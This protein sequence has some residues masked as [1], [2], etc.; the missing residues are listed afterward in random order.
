LSTRP[1]LMYN[2]NLRESIIS[3][4]APLPEGDH[5]HLMHDNPEYVGFIRRFQRTIYSIPDNHI[6]IRHA[7]ENP[8]PLIAGNID[9]LA[10]RQEAW[11]HA[12]PMGDATLDVNRAAYRHA[13]HW[14]FPDPS[15]AA[16]LLVVAALSLMPEV[17]CIC[18]A[19]YGVYMTTSQWPWP[20]GPVTSHTTV[21]E[22]ALPPPTGSGPPPL[23]NLVSTTAYICSPGAPCMS[24]VGE[25]PDFDRAITDGFMGQVTGSFAF[26]STL[27]VTAAL[28]PTSQMVGNY[29]TLY[30]ISSWQPGGVVFSPVHS[31]LSTT[32]ATLTSS[33]WCFQIDL[34]VD[35]TTIPCSQ[36]PDGGDI[37]ACLDPM[38]S[39][40]VKPWM[41]AYPTM[42]ALST[43]SSCWL[44]DPD[45]QSDGSGGTPLPYL[46]ACSWASYRSWTPRA[47]VCSSHVVGWALSAPP[48]CIG[49]TT[50]YTGPTSG[51]APIYLPKMAGMV[52]QST[53]ATQTPAPVTILASPT[54]ATALGLQTSSDPGRTSIV[55]TNYNGLTSF[56]LINPITLDCGPSTQGVPWGLMS[57]ADGDT[58]ATGSECTASSTGGGSGG[59]YDI[60]G[61]ILVL[62]PLLLSLVTGGSGSGFS[63]QVRRRG[64]FDKFLV[65]LCLGPFCAAHQIGGGGDGSDGVSVSDF[66]KEAALTASEMATQTS[67]DAQMDTYTQSL[68]YV[69][70]NTSQNLYAGVQGVMRETSHLGVDI[71]ADKMMVESLNRTLRR[72][73]ASTMSLRLGLRDLSFHT[74]AVQ[75]LVSYRL[76][77]DRQS[78]IGST[79]LALSQGQGCAEAVPPPPEAGVPPVGYEVVGPLSCR[80]EYLGRSAA[81]IRY[82]LP[83]QPVNGTMVNVTIYEPVITTREGGPLYIATWA[84]PSNSS[85]LQVSSVMGMPSA[86]RGA[87]DGR[88]IPPLVQDCTRILLATPQ[89]DPI[90]LVATWQE[91]TTGASVSTDGCPSPAS[92]MKDAAGLPSWDRDVEVESGAAAVSSILTNDGM[93]ALLSLTS[94]THTQQY[95]IQAEFDRLVQ[96]TSSRTSALVTE[97]EFASQLADLA[98]AGTAQ[99]NA[100]SSAL[101]MAIVTS[102]LLPPPDGPGSIPDLTQRLEAARSSLGSR[103]TESTSAQTASLLEALSAVSSSSQASAVFQSSTSL[104]LSGI[105]LQRDLDLSDTLNTQA[106]IAS[107]MSTSQS[108]LMDRLSELSSLHA[109]MSDQVLNMTAEISAM[110]QFANSVQGLPSNGGEEG[111]S[112][113]DLSCW[114]R[115]IM[116]FLIT[117]AVMAAVLYVFVTVALPLGFAALKSASKSA[118]FRSN[119]HVDTEAIPTEDHGRSAHPPVRSAWDHAPAQ[120]SSTDG[121]SPMHDGGGP[122]YWSDMSGYGGAL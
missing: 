43:I 71:A 108:D 54:D 64:F 55:I 23:P 86:L 45:C 18:T 19:P 50:Q 11:M 116:V 48:Q 118:R 100:I 110:V 21:G 36:Q 84:D 15:F 121:P 113:W 74:R 20:A 75:S 80:V 51:S 112:T 42:S 73:V 53:P 68:A 60:T 77:L 62:D 109:N 105:Q 37:T 28:N 41:T 115:K 91:C 16:L 58:V 122:G 101:S 114:F 31:F 40:L 93:S 6:A 12:Q 52:A 111:C 57:W 95:V 59:S 29:P 8:P 10:T 92:L 27:D 103:I 66:K 107:A 70:G 106:S 88:P 98:S 32:A 34:I 25:D 26:P 78:I 47:E 46:L 67:W 65:Q 13:R 22:F 17:Q 44:G 14:R 120:S 97:T 104:T 99:S 38:R 1:F 81:R 96:E 7:V 39:A 3:Q 2:N 117:L 102:A 30:P 69:I 119:V 94:G 61:P 79:L 5:D 87:W 56:E 49:D 35:G 24:S 82:F 85:L 83:V 90:A 33:V 63:P 89:D 72:T 76:A 9:N 4:G